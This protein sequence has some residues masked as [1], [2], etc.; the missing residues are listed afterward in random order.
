MIKLRELFE[1]D[2]ESFSN[3]KPHSRNTRDY[4]VYVYFED[5]DY[6]R[7]DEE[8]RN[9]YTQLKSL[10]KRLKLHDNLVDDEFVD[11]LPPSAIFTFDAV[12]PANHFKK[13]VEADESFTSILD[14]DIE[15]PSVKI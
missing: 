2:K 10:V 7:Y 11:S 12:E 4:K 8:V 6:E 9:T 13:R 14:V 1:F 3:Q 15:K 5:E